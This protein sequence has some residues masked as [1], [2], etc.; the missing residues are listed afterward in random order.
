MFI[1]SEE[2]LQN[3]PSLVKIQSKPKLISHA[4]TT[5]PVKATDSPSSTVMLLAARDCSHSLL[6]VS[7]YPLCSAFLR[8]FLVLVKNN[9]CP[10]NSEITGILLAPADT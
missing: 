6:S 10:K 8:I 7:F 4:P 1:E 3:A 2:S 5:T 9:L